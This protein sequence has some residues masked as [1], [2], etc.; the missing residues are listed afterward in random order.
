M[1]NHN[2]HFMDGFPEAQRKAHVTP[3][4]IDDD[5]VKDGSWLWLLAGVAEELE[6]EGSGLVCSVFHLTKEGRLRLG[7]QRPPC[8]HLQSSSAADL[9]WGLGQVPSLA[10]PV[11]YCTLVVR[12]HL[13][14]PLLLPADPSYAERSCLLVPMLSFPLRGF[15]CVS[16]VDHGPA[17]RVTAMLTRHCRTLIQQKSCLLTGSCQTGPRGLT[18]PSSVNIGPHSHSRAR[19]RSLPPHGWASFRHCYIP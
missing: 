2:S 18:D 5:H 19:T 8:S 1:I 7:R 4:G 6:R 15:V 11:G 13:F 10:G 17:Q 16:G 14:S 12:L 9:P 3:G